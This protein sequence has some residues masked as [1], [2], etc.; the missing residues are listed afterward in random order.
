MHSATTL[1]RENALKHRTAA[2]SLGVLR[3]HLIFALRRSN[4]AQDDSVLV[5]TKN[6]PQS[7]YDSLRIVTGA[8]G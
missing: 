3:L 2:L 7:F 6:R 8:D 4:S 5:F 1:H